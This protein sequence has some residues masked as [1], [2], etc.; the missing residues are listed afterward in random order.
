LAKL[1]QGFGI[2]GGGIDGCKGIC[3]YFFGADALQYFLCLL[4]IA[5]EISLGGNGFFFF[6]LAYLDIV[7]KGTSSRRQ[8]VPLNLSVGL[9]SCFNFS[10]LKGAD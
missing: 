3:P 7:V 2:L 1:L 4:R 8:R 10:S 5:P 6:Y 9:K